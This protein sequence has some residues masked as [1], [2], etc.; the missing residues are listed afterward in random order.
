[1]SKKTTEQMLLQMLVNDF[2]EKIWKNKKLICPSFLLYNLI[3]DKICCGFP[4]IPAFAEM[5]CCR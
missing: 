5:T 2:F 4:W 3:Y 1:M